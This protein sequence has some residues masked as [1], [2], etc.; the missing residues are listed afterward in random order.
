LKDLSESSVQHEQLGNVLDLECSNPEELQGNKLSTLTKQQLLAGCDKLVNDDQNVEEMLLND[1]KVS[2]ESR[3][4]PI[5][6]RKMQCLQLQNTQPAMML[7]IAEEQKVEIT[8]PEEQKYELT[9]PKESKST[10]QTLIIILVCAILLLGTLTL[11]I[12]VILYK[13][14]SLNKKST[15]HNLSIKA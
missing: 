13:R 14:K 3:N 5:A 4:D 6:K 9:I 7:S 15:N 11:I 10:N 8:I 12:S 2:L 1:T